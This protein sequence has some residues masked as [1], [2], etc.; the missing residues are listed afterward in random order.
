MVDRKNETREERLAK[1]LRDNLAR[2]KARDRA[3][4]QADAPAGR[5]GEAAGVRMSL[6]NSLSVAVPLVFGA[7]GSSVGL[8]PVLWAVSVLLAAGGWLTR[9][10][11][12]SVAPQTLS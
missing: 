10:K 9:G 2:R 6:M 3:A 11:K 4:A 7:V 1:A 8:S 12:T 5:M